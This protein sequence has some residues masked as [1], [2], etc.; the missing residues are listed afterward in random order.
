MSRHIVSDERYNY[1][2]GWDQPLQSFYFQKHDS[3]QDEDNQIIVWLGADCETIMY[4][5]DDLGRAAHKHGLTLSDEMRT[6]LYRDRDD[7][8]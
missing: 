8:C 2:F 7:G 5:L 3:L 6:K 4:E 1:V